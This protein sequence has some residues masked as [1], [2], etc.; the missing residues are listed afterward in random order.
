[1]RKI[2]AAKRNN[3][4]ADTAD[5]APKPNVVSSP[6][7]AGPLNMRKTAAGKQRKEAAAEE[8]DVQPQEYVAE[9]ETTTRALPDVA[10]KDLTLTLAGVA[11]NDSTS[12]AHAIAEQKEAALIPAADT[13]QKDAALTAEG[14]ENTADSTCGPQAGVSSL[15]LDAVRAAAL[16]QLYAGL[17]GVAVAEIYV[18]HVLFHLRL[19]MFT[20]IALISISQVYFPLLALANAI[21]LSALFFARHNLK[22][23]ETALASVADAVTAP[24]L[25]AMPTYAES[26]V[27]LDEL[28]ERIT[29]SSRRVEQ[30]KAPAADR[31]CVLGRLAPTTSRMVLSLALRAVLYAIEK[32]YSRELQVGEHKLSLGTVKHILSGELV[33]MVMSPFMSSITFYT[34]LAFAESAVLTFVPF[35]LACWLSLG[36]PISPPTMSLPDI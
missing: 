3:S 7:D 18:Y 28:R 6:V 12:T 36:D 14:L 23:L 22:R 27:S 20:R 17:A 32:R 25:R 11:R 35:G 5:M 2:V 16:Y 10:R 9:K 1:M 13:T 4:E 19:P 34:V 29:A 30:T 33:G 31:S 8:G 15:V 24:L 21:I 26:G